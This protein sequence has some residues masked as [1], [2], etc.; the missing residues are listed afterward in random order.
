MKIALYLR[1]S[2]SS[3]TVE[4]QR[5]DLESVASNAEWEIVEIYKD[6][7]ISGAKGRKGRPGLDRML[8]DATRRRFKKLLVWDISRLGRSL[9][10]LIEITREL[11]KAGV[12]LYFHRDAVDTESASGRLFFHIVGAIGEFERERVS[13]RILSGL[14]RAK[15][16]GKVLGRPKGSFT[17]NRSKIRKLRDEGNSIRKVAETLKI[18]PS[19]VQAAL[20]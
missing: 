7:G 1:V 2:T 17:A 16:Q 4:N 8:K 12:G 6:E 10:D 18:S 20:K 9:G 11:E 3:Q 15:A 5:R 14:E 13:E 19:T